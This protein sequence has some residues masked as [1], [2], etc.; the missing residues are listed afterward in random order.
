MI[1]HS[2]YFILISIHLFFVLVEN[3]N[4]S[5]PLANREI[6]K[7]SDINVPSKEQQNQRDATCSNSSDNKSSATPCVLNSKERGRLD[8]SH[9]TPAYDLTESDDDFL[10]RKFEAALDEHHKQQLQQRSRA[11]SSA[12]SYR[13]GSNKTDSRVF[14]S[15]EDLEEIDKMSPQKSSKNE[16]REKVDDCPRLLGNVARKIIDIEKSLQNKNNK[17][18]PIFISFITLFLLSCTS[19][20]KARISVWRIGINTDAALVSEIPKKSFTRKSMN[21]DG[22]WQ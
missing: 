15:T 8:K 1:T 21:S 11:A 3:T 20:T 22:N 7:D 2:F 13:S 9:S 19:V 10:E 12:S 17:R 18:Y 6:N 14:D 5:Q 4:S 16:N